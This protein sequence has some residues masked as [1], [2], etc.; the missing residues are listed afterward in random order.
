MVTL[1]STL[2]PQQS[3]RHC[4]ASP[5]ACWMSTPK[6]NSNIK[7]LT[8]NK[9]GKDTHFIVAPLGPTSFQRHYVRKAWTTYK[10]FFSF[11][12]FFPFTQLP[13]TFLHIHI[14]YLLSVWV[15]LPS[16]NFW[17][18]S[19]GWWRYLHHLRRWWRYLQH[20]RGWFNENNFLLTS[21]QNKALNQYTLNDSAQFKLNKATSL[22]QL[23]SQTC[24]YWWDSLPYN[25]KNNK[26]LKCYTLVT[27]QW[28]TYGQWQVNTTTYVPSFGGT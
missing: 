22:L 14:K 19:S 18:F 24:W 23:H 20:P 15:P 3:A 8:S 13:I 2:I 7:I 17:S 11:S 10:F 4:S 5:I 25:G 1:T 28:N 26:Q 6:H 12:S 9:Q 27:Q 16:F 21:T